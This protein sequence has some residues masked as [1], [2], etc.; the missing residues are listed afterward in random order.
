MHVLG[1]AGWVNIYLFVSLFSLAVTKQP[2]PRTASC[3]SGVKLGMAPLER[4]RLGKG[5]WLLASKFGTGRV[6]PLPMWVERGDG[7]TGHAVLIVLVVCR[8]LWGYTEGQKLWYQQ[9][10][11]LLLP[12]VQG[13]KYEGFTIKNVTCTIP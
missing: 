7:D 1:W 8:S 10:F 3:L 2:D 11:C 6:A 13:G 9:G 12:S 5:Y 4:T